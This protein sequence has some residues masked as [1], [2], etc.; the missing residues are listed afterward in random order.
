MPKPDDVGVG[1]AVV[2][3]NDKHQILLGLRKGSHRAGHWS[4]PG[5]WL[6]RSDWG[7]DA[8]VARETLEETG[9][10]LDETQLGHLCWTTEEHLDIGV[11]TVTLYHLCWPKGWEGEAK[12]MEPDKCEEWKWFDLDDLP[13][14]LFPGI[15]EAVAQLQ[16]KL[17]VLG[18][19]TG[20]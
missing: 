16:D 4:V 5:G 10:I 7:T 2:I 19:L 12:L 18:W 15:P 20:E 13:S 9:L 11:R 6:D 8:A 14:P 1:T 3:L 17:D